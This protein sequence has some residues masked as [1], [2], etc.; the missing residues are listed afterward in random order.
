MRLIE[1]VLERLLAIAFPVIGSVPLYEH[2][3][4]VIAFGNDEIATLGDLHEA[5]PLE[6]GGIDIELV[7]RGKRQPRLQVPLIRRLSVEWRVQYA[8]PKRSH[9]TCHE[10]SNPN[11]NPMVLH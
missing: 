4:A 8:G 9:R 2:D 10:H 1:P 5:R 7:A 6:A 3:L 11:E